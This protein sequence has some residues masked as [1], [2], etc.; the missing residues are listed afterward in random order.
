MQQWP[1]GGEFNSR[2][3]GHGVE[4]DL[5]CG[6]LQWPGHMMDVGAVDSFPTNDVQTVA[7][8]QEIFD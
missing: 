5:G 3:P 8:G 2:R 1:G 4:F 7:L 6:I